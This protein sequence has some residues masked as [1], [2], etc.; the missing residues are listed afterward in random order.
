MT[1]AMVAM[2]A[3]A[4]MANASAAAQDGNLLLTGNGEALWLVRQNPDRT[5][6]VAVKLPG[7]KWK[8]VAEDSSGLVAAAAPWRGQLHVVL[9]GGK[10]H[11]IFPPSDAEPSIG[12]NPTDPLWPAGTSPLA[13]AEANQVGDFTGSVLVVVPRP[14]GLAATGAATEPGASSDAPSPMPASPTVTTVPS[15]GRWASSQALAATPASRTA[16]TA[17]HAA[18]PPWPTGPVDLGL[19]LDTGLEWKHVA[20]LEKVLLPAGS[21]VLAAVMDHRVYVLVESP[22]GSSQLA[23]L[24]SANA[25]WLDLPLGAQQ[26]P[27]RSLAL[28]PILNRLALVRARGDAQGAPAVLELTT[29]APNSA[30]EHQP[31][32]PPEGLPAWE[33]GQWPLVS[34]L[35]D[36]IAVV[37]QA[38]PSL[39]LATCDLGG[40]L[41]PQGEANIFSEP[42]T[43]TDGAEILR[44][45]V[46]AMMTALLIPMLMMRQPGPPRPFT[47]PPN[48]Q[49]GNLLKRLAAG[50]LD[51]LPF[52]VLAKATTAISF[53]FPVSSL[54]PDDWYQVVTQPQMVPDNAAYAVITAVLLYVAYCF[55]FEVRYSTTPGKMLMKLRVVGDDGVRP[56]PRAILIRNM[57]RAVELCGLPAILLI[58]LFNRNRQ[59]PGDLFARTAVISAEPNPTE[60]KK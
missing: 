47:L 25:Q 5:F 15:T 50:L 32:K 6:D 19:F 45:F 26:L 42:Q 59:R 46:L 33:K 48:L 2:T 58:V 51:F 18:R 34:R 8:W 7:P 44:V 11:V 3:V 57:A 52:V 20:D 14:A 53:L 17:P 16:A 1:L 21:R 9:A 4:A 39:Q 30:P 13:I 37:W 27:A 31:I 41:V 55:V 60:E 35:G 28:M 29:F 56:G 54:S 23:C 12:P 43:P 22:E 24:D 40:Q 49:P 10:G 38:G 36:R